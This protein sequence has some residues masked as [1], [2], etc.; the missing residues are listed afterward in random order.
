MIH[1]LLVAAPEFSLHGFRN[2]ALFMDSISKRDAT[3]NRDVKQLLSVFPEL[4]H[5]KAALDFNH[6]RN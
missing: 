5:R 3:G 6:G 4:P 2:E 1:V